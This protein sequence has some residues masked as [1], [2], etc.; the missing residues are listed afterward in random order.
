MVSLRLISIGLFHS[1]WIALYIHIFG[2]E[3]VCVYIRFIS[4]RV[5]SSVP[6]PTAV[7]LLLIII[8]L[9]IIL[10]LFSTIDYLLF[11]NADCS[12]EPRLLRRAT[13]EIYRLIGTQWQ[14]FCIYFDFV[15]LI[16]VKIFRKNPMR[17]TYDVC[18]M[19]YA[20]RHTGDSGKIWIFAETRFVSNS[21]L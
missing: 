18:C 3:F 7:L 5:I 15:S 4:D 9:T 12:E 16:L 2:G 1:I 10:C 13:I 19:P 6:Q 20:V 14:P 21:A 17:M 8:I 11:V